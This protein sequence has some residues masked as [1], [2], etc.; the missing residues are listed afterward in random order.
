MHRIRILGWMAPALLAGCAAVAPGSG[1]TV[2]LAGRAAEVRAAE[3]A[4]SRSMAE[5]DFAAF[6]AHV[7]DDAVFIGGGRPLRGKAAVLAQW[8][9]YF[10]GPVAPFTWQPEIVEVAAGGELGYSEGP[11]TNADGKG[12]V[13]FAST[14]RRSPATGRWQVVFDNG[15]SVCNCQR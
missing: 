2:D 10:D 8:K 1:G 11:V 15:Y 12:A 5:R 9:A 4:F 13:R 3:I 14:W 7:A 6:A